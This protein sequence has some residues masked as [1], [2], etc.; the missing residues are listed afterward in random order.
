VFGAISLL[1][2]SNRV[3]RRLPLS[4]PDRPGFVDFAKPR[5]FSTYV[6]YVIRPSYVIHGDMGLLR[7]TSS[8]DENLDNADTMMPFANFFSGRILWD[9][10][11]ASTAYEWTRQNKGGL[12]V[13]LV[14]ADHVKFQNG[15]PGRYARMAGTTFDCTSVMLNP[16]L[17]DTRPPGSVANVPRADSSDF[18]DQLTLQLRYLKE[19]VDPLLSP[20]RAALPESTGG[21]MSLA[22]YLLIG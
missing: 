11:M 5:Q 17:I 12:L 1:F 20:L 3:A 9:E 15:I 2:L 13:G 16:T 7:Y 4:R 22:D 6:D 8:R 18:P 21:V 14:G 10:A 19:D